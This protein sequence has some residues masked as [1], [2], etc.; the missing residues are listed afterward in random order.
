MGLRGVAVFS[1]ADAAA[2]FVRLADAALA[3]GPATATESYLNIEAVIGAAKELGADLVHPGY[4]FLAEDARFAEACEQAGLIF[5]GPGA[6]LLRLMGA[7][8][9]AKRVA[10]GAGAPVLQGYAGR[11]QSDA[12]FIAAAAD[13]IGYPLILK[14]V[15]GGGGK[16]MSVVH[17]PDDLLQAL[18]GARRVALAAF[19]D[20]RLMIEKFL[21]DPRHVEVQ[22][23]ADMYGNVVH[24]GERDCSAQRRHQKIC[25]ETPAP[26]IDQQTRVRL[27]DAAVALARTVGYRSVGTCE[28]LVKDGTVAFMEMNARLQVE[29]PVT[30]LVT[31][32]DLVEIQI[33]IALEESLPFTQEQVS[34]DGHAME[35]RLYAED[36]T[37]DF[38]PQTGTIHHLRWPEGI[39][40]DS[41]VE[42]GSEISTHYDPMIAKLIMHAQGRAEALGKLSKALS[43]IEVLGIKTNLAFLRRFVASTEL[44][45]ANVTTSTVEAM[46]SIEESY[47][48]TDEVLSL[49]AAAE[50][51]R[52][53]DPGAVDPWVRAGGWRLGR[54]AA[55]E[56]I[57]RVDDD[58]LPL[59]VEW[60]G[61]YRV[62][63]RAVAIADG[64]HAWTV[65]GHDASAVWG[66]GRWYIWSDMTPYEVLIGHQTRTHDASTAR[67]LEA[68]MPGQVLAVRVQA[69]DQ[70]IKGQELVVVEAMKMEHSVKA[71][72][73]GTIKAVLCF[74]GEVV[75]KGKVLVDLET[76]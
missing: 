2:P 42:E 62:G 58:E 8:D 26:T 21:E 16:G 76:D 69:G 60:Q 3:I 22:V 72:S 33:R 6:P 25:E 5:V 43:E 10:A 27:T 40:V 63:D 61:P 7:K 45:E 32:M 48:P 55:I 68:P 35:V 70:V 28:F 71:P 9:E 4:G 51:D 73:P 38:L 65:D 18:A 44:A 74:V 19:A 34:F 41:G 23:V 12:A 47:P 67:H 1:E 31:G 17:D 39:R 52:L 66:D 15:A 20:E 49:A 13:D 75:I 37:R 29:H 59:S 50:A 64:C 36:P 46:G 11:D 54:D 56:V 53:R 57:V 14:P 24:L 30:E